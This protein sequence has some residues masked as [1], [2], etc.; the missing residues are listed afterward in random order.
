MT[1]RLLTDYPPYKNGNAATFDAATE[2]SLIAKGIAT[3]DLTGATT[4]VAPVPRLAADWIPLQNNKTI[5]AADDGKC[6]ACMNA[7]TITFPSGLVPRPNI[8]AMPPPSGS[9]S[10]V[11]TLNGA[12]QTLTRSRANNPAGVAITPYEESDG[13]GVNGS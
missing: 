3:A 4:Y 10:L 12:S 11:G 7:L 6:Y 13:Y 1:V 2:T 9:V 8:I 5:E